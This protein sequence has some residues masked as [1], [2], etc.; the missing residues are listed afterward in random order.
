MSRHRIGAAGFLKLMQ[1]IEMAVKLITGR[2]EVF[3][4]FREP[5]LQHNT[6]GM[7]VAIPVVLDFFDNKRA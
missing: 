2:G 1:S 6:L 3:L 5:V 4:L 7:A